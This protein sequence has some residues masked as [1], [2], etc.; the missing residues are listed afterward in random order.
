[1]AFLIRI[2]EKSLRAAR[3]RW[4]IVI[5]VA[6]L[7]SC[8][9][10]LVE[11][12]LIRGRALEAASEN[13]HTQI[14]VEHAPRGR[15][16]DRHGKILA[17]NQPVFVAFFSPLGLSPS[18]LQHILERLS[19]I[20]AV[21]KPELEHR[22]LAALRAKTMLRVSDQLSRD[23]AFLILQN[24]VHLPG[25][26]L[27]IEEQR[28]YPG[29]KLACHV[30]GYVGQITD[31]ELEQ[32]A[33]KGYHPGDWIGKTGL[34]RLYD[35]L[36]QG[37][38]GGFL[39]EVDAL[40]RQVRILQHLPPQAGKDLYLTLDKDLEE[41][42]EKR[43][44][45]TGHPGAAVMLNPQTGEVLVL[46]SSPGYDPNAFLPSGSS[47]ERTR[48]LNDT[49]LHPLYNRAIQALYPPGS[50][51]KIVTSLADLE[52]HALDTEEKIRCTG[53]YTLGLEKRIFHCWKLKGH[54]LMDFH[55]AVAESCDVYFYQVGL[56]LGPVLIEKYAKA[57]GLGRPSGVDLPS[58]KRGLLPY[59]WKTSIGQHWQGGD[60]LNYAIGQGALQVTPIQMADLAALVAN[61]G[62][63]NQPFLAVESRRYGEE[64][65]RLMT[66]REALRID[67]SKVT[68][69]LLCGALEEVV[70]TG[71]GLASQI[72]GF[73][74]AGKTGTAQ[75]TKGKEH[76]WFV[77]YAPADQPTVACAVLVEHGGHGG[78]VSAP[79][80]HDL[81]A[82]ALGAKEKV[83]TE[84]VPAETQAD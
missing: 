54:G 15:I 30:L 1:M 52:E 44:Q 38:D 74:V 64:S 81:L 18:D 35:P 47:E 67:L 25:V 66:P 31:E 2:S 55:R 57:V 62:I 20:V 69:K 56:K 8:F 12:Q 65:E 27:T 36:L 84:S 22:L 63:L 10:R 23:Q 78:S 37:Q 24:R 41:L 59:V 17:D 82:L 72:P 83:A 60:T 77:A 34:E 26:S 45:E 70:R 3:A 53:S 49:E 71:T 6:S 7:G 58:E 43:L 48:L 19:P 21:E 61:R 13:N 5:A 28:T 73:A 46:A 79:I 29:G 14:L 9:L 33:D 16:L 75:A 40:G 11:L 51:F 50:I 42:A 76:G 80:A 39:M 32:F 68:W 4:L